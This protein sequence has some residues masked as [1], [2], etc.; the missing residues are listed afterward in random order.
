MT[1]SKVIRSRK[2]NGYEQRK[3]GHEHVLTKLI[4]YDASDTID[5]M[6]RNT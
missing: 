2:K 3:D 5:L 4:K 6:K 1:T